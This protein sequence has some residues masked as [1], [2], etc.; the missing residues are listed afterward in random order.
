MCARLAQ[1]ARM[2][3]R[4]PKSPDRVTITI[5]PNLRRHIEAIRQAWI[6]THP[7]TT[8]PDSQIVEWCA[9]R[10]APDEAALWN[11]KVTEVT[12]K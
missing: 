1:S 6:D 2:A 12:G 4:K 11:A 3:Q 5:T 8:I 10:G 7:G 9:M